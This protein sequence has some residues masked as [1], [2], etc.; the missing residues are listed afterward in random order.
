MRGEPETGSKSREAV[1]RGHGHWAGQG[2]TEATSSGSWSLRE[3]QSAR[4]IPQAKS[5]EKWPDSSGCPGRFLQ[6]P[7]DS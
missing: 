7:R 6:V 3:M 4:D 1:T 5:E 2:T